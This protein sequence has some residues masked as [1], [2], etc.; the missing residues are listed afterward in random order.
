[1]IQKA[2]NSKD[3]R[4]KESAARGKFNKAVKSLEALKEF[5][6]GDDLVKMIDLLE[7]KFPSV[8]QKIIHSTPI[9]PLSSSTSNGLEH[10][11][12]GAVEDVLAETETKAKKAK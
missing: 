1:M 10:L 11:P 6:L 7:G 4:K 12:A 9:V 5:D 3:L 2:F 8:L